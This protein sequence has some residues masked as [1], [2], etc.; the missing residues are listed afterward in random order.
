MYQQG[1]HLSAN[2]SAR[3]KRLTPEGKVRLHCYRQ[4]MDEISRQNEHQ[5]TEREAA[6]NSQRGQNKASLQ[7]CPNCSQSLQEN[8]CKLV[9]PR[10]G[11]YLSC[12]DFY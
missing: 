10:C 5:P 1:R 4:V 12:S 2:R 6:T 11:Y 8:H 3:G 9:C 7:V